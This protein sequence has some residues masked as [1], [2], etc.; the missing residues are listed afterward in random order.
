[1][2]GYLYIWRHHSKYGIIGT[3]FKSRRTLKSCVFVRHVELI[4]KHVDTPDVA[5]WELRYYPCLL[6][7]VVSSS[8]VRQVYWNAEQRNEEEHLAQRNQDVVVCIYAIAENQVGVFVDLTLTLRNFKIK[9][10]KQT[11]PERI[12]EFTNF[13]FWIEASSQAA[14]NM[15]R[16]YSLSQWIRIFDVHECLI[17]LLTSQ[18]LFLVSTEVSSRELLLYEGPSLQSILLLFILS[19]HLNFENF[20]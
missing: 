19:L 15:M 6:V 18:L 5:N 4:T 3:E 14:C 2:G 9:L 16:V 12:L 17:D 10:L 13:I 11:L 7:S 8:A 1:M 20:K